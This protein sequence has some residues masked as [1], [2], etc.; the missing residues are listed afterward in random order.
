MGITNI[1]LKAFIWSSLT[2]LW[3]LCEKGL[4]GKSQLYRAT[5]S[6]FLSKLSNTFIYLHLLVYFMLFQE[7]E[8]YHKYWVPR[9]WHVQR[10][11]WLPDLY[12]T[13][14]THLSEV[15][16]FNWSRKW[17]GLSP[18]SR[19]RCTDAG[20]GSL[21]NRCLPLN[22]SGPVEEKQILC[23]PINR[24]LAMAWRESRILVK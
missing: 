19:E 18:L 7:G 3:N 17:F 5:L 15:F 22:Q 12:N 13:R 24:S 23:S 9:H 6:T 10:N 1:V 16:R 11:W 21:F 20:V 4:E 2:N 14:R 8:F